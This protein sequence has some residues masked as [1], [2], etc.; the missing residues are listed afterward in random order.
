MKFSYSLTCF[1]SILSV[2]TAIEPA[3]AAP[4]LTEMVPMR[5][6][7]H[8]ATDV[9]LPQ[10]DGPFPVILVMTP[11]N[12]DGLALWSIAANQKGYALVAQDFRGRFASEGNDYPVF[13]SYGWGDIQDGYDTVEWIAMQEWC[14]GKVGTLGISGP[15]IA[16][17]MMAPTAPPHLVCQY[18]GVAW[19]SAYHQ[20]AYQGGAFRKNLTERWLNDC[21]FAPD[22]LKLIR[23]HPNY[24]D[25]WKAQNTELV[26]DRVNVPSMFVGGWYDIFNIGT[27]NSFK[28]IQHN[29]TGMAKGNCKLVMQAYG[30][31]VNEELVFPNQGFPKN[32]DFANLGWFDI[33]LKND[34]KGAEEIPTVQYF[35]MGDPEDKNANVWK[36]AD[37]WAIPSKE[38][39]YYFMPDGSLKTDMPEID[40]LLSYRYDPNDPV[41]TLGGAELYDPKG[42]MDQ[43]SIEDRPDVIL[44]TSEALEQPLEV[45]G[46][47]KVKLWASS[48]APDTDFTAKLCD[49]YPDGRSIIVADGIIR[50]CY[51]NSFEK[52]ELLESGKIYEF[53]IDLWDTAILFSKGHKIRV[54]ISSSNAPRFEPNPNTGKPSGLD[55]ETRIATNTIYLG[56]KHP[57]CITLPVVSP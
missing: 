33:W 10:G 16:Q 27:I 42:P 55:D 43:R 38:T 5:D 45:V 56:K 28:T 15:G 25:Y 11:Y 47:L 53:E 8:L 26:A 34:G 54:A 24:D 51:R 18:V 22:T 36:S 4:T 35:V 23:E 39:P 57:S 30:H 46:S 29:G 49:V 12:K 32:A 37:D 9:Y 21:Q 31:G 13:L 19:S 6:G 41:P 2:L 48:D 7:V 20:M 40:K 17:N 14:N 50:A 52:R 44:F 1:V 3:P